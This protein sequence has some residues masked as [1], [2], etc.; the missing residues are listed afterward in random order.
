MDCIIFHMNPNIYYTEYI[1]MK[2][3]IFEMGMNKIWYKKKSFFG[4]DIVSVCFTMYINP[5]TL[6]NMIIV[7]YSFFD[8]ANSQRYT[9]VNYNICT[10]GILSFKNDC[11]K[12]KSQIF[13][14]LD[15]F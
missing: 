13:K 6:F 9:R 15:S 10:G 4:I 11:E 12:I 2:I 14:I 8:V 7:N 5:N 3:G 1:M